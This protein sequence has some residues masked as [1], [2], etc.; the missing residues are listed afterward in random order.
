MNASGIV[1]IV[2][3]Q[4]WADVMVQAIVL[5]L[6]TISIY[7]D[8]RSRRIPNWLTYSALLAAIVINA[9][10]V[11][12][13]ATS[14]TVIVYGHSVQLPGAIGLR[15]SLV[16][17]IGCFGVMF[18]L[19]DLAGSGGGDLK[20]ATA[21]GAF[22]GVQNGI[23]IILWAH[24]LAGGVLLIWAARAHGPWM[25]A[26]LL[27]RSIARLFFH[28]W[29]SPPRAEDMRLLQKPIPLAGFF[30]AGVLFTLFGVS[31]P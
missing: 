19:Y 2:G 16:G 17:A 31:L 27:A 10:A 26:K 6:L 23:F 1:S 29:I 14:N 24:L 20:L 13:E 11:P 28:R 22:L 12:S 4:Y 25:L 15:A 30:A 5:G 8:C 21:L 18:V 3:G 9:I 7:T